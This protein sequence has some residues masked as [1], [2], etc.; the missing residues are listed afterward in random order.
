MRVTQ[1]RSMEGSMKRIMVVSLLGVVLFVVGVAAQ[2]QRVPPQRPAT[3]SERPQAEVLAVGRYQ[4][5]PTM[6]DF[7]KIILLDTVTGDTWTNCLNEVDS[8]SPAASPS[9]AQ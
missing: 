1:A 9:E 8:G 5:I 7:F 3:P 6:D 2:S 4:V